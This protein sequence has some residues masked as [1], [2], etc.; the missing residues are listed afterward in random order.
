M[1]GH[2]P[3]QKLLSRNR[4]ANEMK[5]Y[6]VPDQNEWSENRSSRFEPEYH[7][8]HFQHVQVHPKY[9]NIV[10]RA[11]MFANFSFTKSKLSFWPP[12]GMDWMA[13][14]PCI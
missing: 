3:L 8:F 10:N 7:V 2:G 4:H 1:S 9:C 11:S 14:T 5:T 13:Q 12:E 6:F